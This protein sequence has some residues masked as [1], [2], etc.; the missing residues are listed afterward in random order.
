MYDDIDYGSPVDFDDLELPDPECEEED[1]SE[2][3]TVFASTDE[4]LAA[5][6]A[7]INTLYSVGELDLGPHAED[8]AGVENAAG[9]EP[10]LATPPMPT[11]D[12]PTGDTVSA[13]AKAGV[14]AAPATGS[15]LVGVLLMSLLVLGLFAAT[16]FLAT[17]VS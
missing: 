6:T 16:I 13:A 7:K 10:T 14:A 15:T 9:A 12:A 5:V 2:D 11:G 4:L 1:V 3:P 17:V 8:A